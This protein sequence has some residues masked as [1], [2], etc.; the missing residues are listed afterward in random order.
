MKEKNWV[1]KLNQPLIEYFHSILPGISKHKELHGQKY[2][3]YPKWTCIT[4]DFQKYN[5]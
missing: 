3:V 2:F 1:P 5:V 4:Y